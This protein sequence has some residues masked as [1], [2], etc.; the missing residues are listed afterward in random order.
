MSYQKTKTKYD[1][2]K[3]LID[4]YLGV[5]NARFSF[6]D[7]K[8]IRES[9]QLVSK[10]TKHLTHANQKTKQAIWLTLNFLTPYIIFAIKRL[11]WDKVNINYALY[12]KENES[13]ETKLS[14]FYCLMIMNIIT[15]ISENIRRHNFYKQLNFETINEKNIIA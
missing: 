4:S 6:Y 13:Y 12:Y 14:S 3:I 7:Q 1:L 2:F 10:R 8:R 5:E 9:H 15:L 11:A